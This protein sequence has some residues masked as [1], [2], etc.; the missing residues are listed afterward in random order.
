MR[1]SKNSRYQ[2]VL[3][4]WLDWDRTYKYI[5][6]G[7]HSQWDLKENSAIPAIPANTSFYKQ[8]KTIPRSPRE[9][10]LYFWVIKFSTI[11]VIG[12]LSLYYNQWPLFFISNLIFCIRQGLD[13]RWPK[14]LTPVYLEKRNAKFSKCPFHLSLRQKDRIFIVMYAYI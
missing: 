9:P 8:N 13:P 1:R 14:E 2:K 12:H 7:R 10:A 5:Q 6:F 3:Y 4:S 11:S